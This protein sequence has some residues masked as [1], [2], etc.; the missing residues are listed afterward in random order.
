MILQNAKILK[1]A[2]CLLLGRFGLR[3][4][5]L[6][7]IGKLSIECCEADLEALGCFF[8][9]AGIIGENLI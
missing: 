7:F 3:I 4:I 2:N 6:R 5:L 1:N 8:L 9:V